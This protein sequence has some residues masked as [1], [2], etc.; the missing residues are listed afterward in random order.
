MLSISAAKQ[1]KKFNGTSNVN[2]SLCE[3]IDL[4]DSDDDEF[5]ESIKYYTVVLVDGTEKRVPDHCMANGFPPDSDKQLPPKTRV[6]AKRKK[7]HFPVRVNENGE[8]DYLYENDDSAFYAGIISYKTFS[9]DNGYCYLVFFDDGHVQYVSSKN[10]RVVFG[11]YGVKFV[12]EN[13]RT[14]YDY[15]FNGPKKCELVEAIFT[16]G[17]QVRTF[18]NSKFEVATVFEYSEEM[19]GLVQLHFEESNI[20]EWLYTGS[21][22]FLFIWKRIVRNNKLKRYHHANT[23]LIEVSSDSEEDDD[24][25]SPTKKPLPSDAKDPR[26]K[27]VR[28]RPELLIDNY[29]PTR[30]LDR[31]HVCGHECVRDNEQNRRIFNFDP[32]KRPL[33]AGWTRKVTGICYYIAPCGRSFNTIENVYK[34]LKTTKSKLS[35]DCFI[36]STN[37]DCMTEVHSVSETGQ[38]HFL[39]EV[40]RRS[41]FVF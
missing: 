36:F 32:L 8:P 15:Y 10:I 33:L 11:D 30:K 39:N 25:Q 4:C 23:T 37:I 38:E 3:L 28:Q 40:S 29:K 27:I 18:L 22:R 41:N 17:K 12:H 24:F 13:A 1:L 31:Q 2:K 7:N 35:I 16:I 21:P 26:K 19:S 5:L 34:Y 20:G 6:I 14:F 9:K